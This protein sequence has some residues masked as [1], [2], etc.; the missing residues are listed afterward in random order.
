MS[1]P[2]V[3]LLGDPGNT[4]TIA[5]GSCTYEFAAGKPRKVPV[6]IALEAKKKM[7]AERPLFSVDGMPRI[8]EVPKVVPFKQTASVD[9]PHYQQ[10]FVV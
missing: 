2:K 7:L 10:A 5:Y 1:L 6:V 4:Y 8:V 3:T 9:L